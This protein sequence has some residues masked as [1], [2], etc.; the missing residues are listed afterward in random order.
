M[1]VA[2]GA[3]SAYTFTLVRGALECTPRTALR[4]RCLS[5]AEA[6]AQ[7]AQGFPVVVAGGDVMTF[8]RLWEAEQAEQAERAAR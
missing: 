5:P 7:L 2:G 4:A 6:V 1:A 3:T 8:R